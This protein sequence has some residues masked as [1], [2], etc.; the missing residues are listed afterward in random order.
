MTRP[1]SRCCSGHRAEPDNAVIR[2]AASGPNIAAS[3]H[4]DSA[5]RHG[6]RRL[7][8]V[9]HG[10]AECLL[11]GPAVTGH[12]ATSHHNDAAAV[13]IPEIPSDFDPA[14]ERLVACGR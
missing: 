4:R 13:V 7:R 9:D 3:T 2:C 11:E 5:Y 10:N 12:A 6:D 1:C 14:I 8:R